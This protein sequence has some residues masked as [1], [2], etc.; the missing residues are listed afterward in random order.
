MVQFVPVPVK[1]SSKGLEALY[2]TVNSKK[3]MNE[4]MWKK[5]VDFFETLHQRSTQ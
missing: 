3:G 2:F 1:H 4:E 5:V